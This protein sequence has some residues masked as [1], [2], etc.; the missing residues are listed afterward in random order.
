MKIAKRKL[1]LK[2][3]SQMIIFNNLNTRF[4]ALPNCSC[5][6]VK[7]KKKRHAGGAAGAQVALLARRRH[8]TDWLFSSSY[9]WY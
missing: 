9:R 3:S 5:V 4:L 1:F 6:T 8:T 2:D 7:G